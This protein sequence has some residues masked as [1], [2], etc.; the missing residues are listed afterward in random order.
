MP[1]GHACASSS[2]YAAVVVVAVGE[3]VGVPRRRRVLVVVVLVV[4]V[5]AAEC[6]AEN[7]VR[8]VE[9]TSR[10]VVPVTSSRPNNTPMNSSGAAIHAVSPSDSGPP[11]AKPMKPA[12]CWRAAGSAGDPAHR[13]HSPSA[14]SAIIAAP[15]ISRGRA[16]GSGSV[17]ISTTATAASAIGNST[18]EE[19]MSTRR[20]VS[21]HAPTGRAASNQ[22]L[23]AIDHGDA[24]QRQRDAVAAV[25]GLEVAGP[26]DRARREPAPLASISQPART[27]RPTVVP[28]EEMRRRVAAAG[29]LPAGR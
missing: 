25:A 27:P 18:T 11:S 16:S 6:R 26:A 28:A 19:P 22:E 8:T 5:I 10:I 7:I 24:Q 9:G 14:G 2:R 12:A 4:V 21:I 15:R 17:R 3:V 13:C 23:A 20:K 29:R 1:V